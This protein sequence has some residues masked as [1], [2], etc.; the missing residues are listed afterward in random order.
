MRL[1]ISRR[2]S[3]WILCAVA[4]AAGPC[5]GSRSQGNSGALRVSVD[6]AAGVPPGGSLTWRQ[7]RTRLSGSAVRGKA[8]RYK[9]SGAGG[10]WLQS[11]AAGHLQLRWARGATALP[12]SRGPLVAFSKAT[13]GG[14][15]GVAAILDAARGDLVLATGKERGESIAVLGWAGRHAGLLLA[16]RRH[17]SP[18]L[19]LALGH[20]RPRGGSLDL[21]VAKSRSQPIL[22]VRATQDLPGF[23]AE[24][25]LRVPARGTELR[26]DLRLSPGRVRTHLG[27]RAS[28]APRTTPMLGSLPP[29]ATRAWLAADVPVVGRTRVA[30]RGEL[31]RSASGDRSRLHAELRSEHGRAAADWISGGGLL[32]GLRSIWRLPAGVVVEA[33]TASWSGP[34]DGAGASPGLPSIPNRGLEPRL[35]RPGRATGFVINWQGRRVRVRLGLS[36]RQSRNTAPDSRFAS[37]IDF[38]LPPLERDP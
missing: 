25:R 1:A 29:P 15:Q 11:W 32:L 5:T 2:R 21:E 3:L 8:A 26:L 19:S 23:A 16:T 30:L 27:A 9:L 12:E 13:S 36:A 33:G 24:F 31:R 22:A 7:G 20:R 10:G 14:F 28:L 6:G 37:R 38:V 35:S 18:R 17:S 4:L 34:V